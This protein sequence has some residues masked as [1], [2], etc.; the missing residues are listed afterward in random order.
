MNK[1]LTVL[2]EIKLN[3]KSNVIQGEGGNFMATGEK[4]KNETEGK[5]KEKCLKTGMLKIYLF[6]RKKIP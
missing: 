1:L 5:K 3:L 4:M 6:G 2:S